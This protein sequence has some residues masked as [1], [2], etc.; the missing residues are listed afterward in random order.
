MLLDDDQRTVVWT[1][2]FRNARPVSLT[3]SPL[4]AMEPAILMETLALAFDDV[5]IR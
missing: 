4:R 3:Y 5:E 1:W 2:R